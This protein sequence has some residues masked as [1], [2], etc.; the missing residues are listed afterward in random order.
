MN[1]ETARENLPAL[2]LG[3]LDTGDAEAVR[4]HL[5]GCP[6]CVRS[7]KELRTVQDA[8]NLAV[9]PVPLP[10]GFSERLLARARSAPAVA[11]ARRAGLVAFRDRQR[12]QWFPWALA[13]ACLVLA[14]LTGGWALRLN[15]RVQAQR[16]WYAEMAALIARPDVEEFDLEPASG[17]AHGVAYMS[18]ERDV[19]CIVL[20]DLPPLPDSRVYQVWLDAPNRK[21]SGGTFVPRSNGTAWVFIRQP[22]GLGEYESVGITVEP[23]GGS[24]GPTTPRILRGEF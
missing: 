21:D 23:R 1:H 15:D 17:S 12:R 8:L 9:D 20:G 14:L 6:D 16:A 24:G 13:A 11:P 2:A 19:A 7:L 4:E 5:L 3:A 10:E 18:P 22:A